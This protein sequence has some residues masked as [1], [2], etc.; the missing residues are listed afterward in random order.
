MNL[1]ALCISFGLWKQSV[2]APGMRFLT[3][4]FPHRYLVA[5]QYL[6]T[7]LW[8][9]LLVKSGEVVL[10]EFLTSYV[11][12]CNGLGVVLGAP[13]RCSLCGGFLTDTR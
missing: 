3:W 9:L 13:R 8:E 4:W 12:W 2:G 10:S 7:G 5:L 1:P 6:N 11:H